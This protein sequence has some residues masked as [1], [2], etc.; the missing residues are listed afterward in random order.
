M[1]CATDAS[2]WKISADEFVDYKKGTKTG[3]WTMIW[4]DFGTWFLWYRYID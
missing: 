1:R 3:I 2:L 4:Y